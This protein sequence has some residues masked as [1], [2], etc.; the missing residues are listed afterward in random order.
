LRLEKRASNGFGEMDPA[1]RANPHISRER[2]NPY[3]IFAKRIHYV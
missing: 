2:E 1:L 3:S